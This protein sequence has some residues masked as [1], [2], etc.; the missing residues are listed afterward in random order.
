MKIKR[1]DTSDLIPFWDEDRQTVSI[2]PAS[3]INSTG[4]RPL[5]PMESKAST[6]QRIIFPLCPDHLITLLQYNALRALL[7]NRQLIAPLKLVT[8]MPTE[9]CSSAATHVLPDSL[10][11][12]VIPP[13]LEPTYLQQTVPHEGWID[14][15][16]H[17]RWRDN[18][19]AAI[20]Q[21]DED[22][23]WSDCIGGLFEGFPDCEI[24]RRGIVAWSPPWDVS[25]WEISEGF[26]RK[27]GWSM[28]RC[29]EIL[30][31]TN[32]WRAMR[33]EDPLVY[34]VEDI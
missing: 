22:E 27:W 34:A 25:G 16:P 14:I 28:K 10:S 2:Q 7:V 6:P 13:S 19:I 3:M 24:E 17:P 12:G 18:V 4:K 29:E 26:W 5:I 32:R 31:A 9:E 21:F 11:P 33:G 23:L 30:D 15:I 1:R 20:G 8:S